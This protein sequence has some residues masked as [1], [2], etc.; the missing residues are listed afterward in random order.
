MAKKVRAIVKVQAQAKSATAADGIR[1]LSNQVSAL[2]EGRT[3]EAGPLAAEMQRQWAQ[4]FQAL[5]EADLKP[6]ER[7]AWLELLR[8]IV[9]VAE[10]DPAQAAYLREVIAGMEAKLKGK[11]RRRRRRRPR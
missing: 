9:T 2:A 6:K 4:P 3:S 11:K 8:R 10:S 5:D 1:R 7:K